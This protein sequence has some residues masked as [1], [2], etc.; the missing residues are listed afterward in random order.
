MLTC[1][2]RTPTEDVDSTEDIGIL[3]NNSNIS[4][5]NETHQDTTS[6]GS[7]QFPILDGTMGSWQNQTQEKKE[8]SDT[9]VILNNMNKNWQEK[10]SVRKVIR[11]EKSEK[12]FLSFIQM[13]TIRLF[14]LIALF[15]IVITSVDPNNFIQKQGIAQTFSE[16]SATSPDVSIQLYIIIDNHQ[17]RSY[18]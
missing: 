15:I 11:Y 12:Q 4:K 3:M 8:D 9:N 13:F 16:N 14:Y 10:T 17:G 18:R 7:Q 6:V 2:T 1:L 5:P